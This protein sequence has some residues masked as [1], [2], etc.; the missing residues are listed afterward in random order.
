MNQ[1]KPTENKNNDQP[2]LKR[3]ESV[4]KRLDLHIDEETVPKGADN[5]EKKSFTNEDLSQ[6]E[7]RGGHDP[8]IEINDKNESSSVEHQNSHSLENSN[9]DLTH[10]DLIDFP[11]SHESNGQHQDSG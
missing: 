8:F 7:G 9:K 1:G 10:S 5:D 11:I 4:A 6:I 3:K 2:Y